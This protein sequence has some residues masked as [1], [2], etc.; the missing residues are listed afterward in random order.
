[1][2]NNIYQRFYSYLKPH[3][4]QLAIVIIALIITSSSI[5]SFGLVLRH[6]VDSSAEGQF[7]VYSFIPAFGITLIFAVA[8]F[9]RA[10]SI[11]AI[12]EKVICK[13]RQ[14]A[15]IHLNYISPYHFE[16]QKTSDIISRLTNDSLIVA[17][18]ISDTFSFALRNGLTAIGCGSLM[19]YVSPKLGFYILIIIPILVPM[20]VF[21]GKKVRKTSKQNQ[22]AISTLSSDIEETFNAIK[23]IQSFNIQEQKITNFI[24]LSNKVL[25]SNLARL[26]VSSSLVSV[27]IFLILSGI[28]I[29]IVLG[30]SEVTQGNLSSGDLSSFIFYSLMGAT[31]LAGIA[32]I[33]SDSQ[34]SFA[35]AERLFGLFDLG[36]SNIRSCSI[37]VA[38]VLPAND[39]S[40]NIKFQN[41]TFYYPA[42]PE[43]KILD[44]ISFEIKAGEFIGVVGK[45]GC[46]KTTIISLL[47]KFYTLSEGAIFVGDK[48]IK[49]I[50]NH[51]LRNI[52]ALV[53]QDP[54]IF[55]ASAKENIMIGNMEA[56]DEEVFE[57]AK[58]AGIYD[59]LIKLPQAF[60]TY[61]GE[62][63]VMLS[64]GQKQRI[65]IARAF[66][67]KPKILLLDEATSALDAAHEEDVHNSIKHLDKNMT[68]IAIAHRIATIQDAD[69]IFVMEKGKI[70]AVGTHAE[71]L[72]KSGLYQELAYNVNLRADSVIARN[73]T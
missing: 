20:I 59:F 21:A 12:C 68:V 8:S 1:M 42:R 67:K 25:N 40:Q 55:S 27:I 18:A 37:P 10:F 66:L 71:L 48:D 57:A 14:D 73:F 31:S 24:D 62:K 16:I 65:A 4:S 35:A 45:S 60:D 47:E 38:N 69:R 2:K 19:L 46:G 26:I 70:S 5:L 36:E 44:D 3:L 64:G 54:F 50:P 33:V 34:R 13:I 17:T 49:D 28:L 51:E 63:G 72:K 32:N 52:M 56:S 30:L 15:Y 41:I 53:P 61:V 58:K 11:Y 22:E 9:I 39:G 29:V 43:E 6:V 7:S 23:T